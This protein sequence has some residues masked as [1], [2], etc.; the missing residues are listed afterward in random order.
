M[1]KEKEEQEMRRWVKV[2]SRVGF[3]AAASPATQ[4]M[5]DGD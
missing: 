3:E 2:P 1:S 4:E 5:H